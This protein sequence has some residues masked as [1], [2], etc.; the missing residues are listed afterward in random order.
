MRNIKLN[1]SDNSLGD[2]EE[3]MKAL[4]AFLKKLT[5]VKSMELIL[6]R[7]DLGENP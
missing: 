5:N 1:L 2:N 6:K 3:D 4:G 7:N